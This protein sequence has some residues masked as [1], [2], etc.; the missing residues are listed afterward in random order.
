[1]RKRSAKGVAALL[2]VLCA[3]A[4]TVLAVEVPPGGEYAIPRFVPYQDPPPT[5][6]WGPFAVPELRGRQWGLYGLC[7]HGYTDKLCAAYFWEDSVRRYRSIDSTNPTYP[8]TILAYRSAGPERDSFQDLYYC[9]YDNSI[10]VHSSKRQKVFKIDAMDGHILRQFPTPATRYPTGIAFDERAKKLYLVDRMLEGGYPCSL[11]VADTLGNVESRRPLNLGYSYAGARC[12]DMDYT[13]SNPNWPS[14]LLIY[15]FFQSSGTLDS[16][17]LFELDRSSLAVLNRARLPDLAGLVNNVRGVAWDPRSGDYWIGIMQNPD[18]NIYKLDGWHTPYSAD[19]GVMALT[20]PR[21]SA[22]SGASI[23]PQMLVRNFGTAAA[24]FPVRMKIGAAYE[25]VRSKTLAAGREDTANFPVWQAR[26]RGYQKVVCITE[27]PGDMFPRN[28]TVTES[29]TVVRRDVACTQIL[30]PSGLL[31]S[32]QVVTPQA[33]VKNFGDENANFAAQFRIGGVYSETAHVSELTPNEERTISFPNWSATGRG[34]LATKC[35]TLLAS[36]MYHDNDW[37]VGTVT[38][39]V[40]DVGVVAILAPTSDTVDSGQIVT[41]RASVRNDGNYSEGF[42]VRMTIGTR[43]SDD[44]SVY[45]TPGANVNVSFASWTAFERGLLAVRCTTR[46]PGDMQNGND[47]LTGWVFVRVRDVAATAIDAPSGIV[48]SGASI[49]PQARIKNLGNTTVSL[50]VRFLVTNGYVDVQN[51]SDLTPDEERT[52]GFTPWTASPRG[53]FATRCTVGLAADQVPANNQQIG[54]VSVSVA[55]VGV[56]AIIDPSGAIDTGTVVTPQAKVKN[57]GSAPAFFPVWFRINPPESLLL[58]ANRQVISTSRDVI[59]SEAKNLSSVVQSSPSPP[60]PFDPLYEDSVWV[61]LSAGDSIIA[62]FAQWTANT[63]GTLPLEAFSALASDLNRSND[64][65]YGA[66]TV[67]PPNAIEEPAAATL[68]PREFALM[69]A[70]PNPFA[71]RTALNY[72]LPIDCPVQLLIYN[73]SGL[74]VR[75]LTSGRDR[76]GIHQVFWNGRDRQGRAVAPGLYF[77]RLEAD[78]RRF[79]RKFVKLD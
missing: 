76:A 40:S 21:T 9:R 57:Y 79:T 78:G 64:T 10:W 28:D 30:G 51:V 47:R 29:L 5:V 26:G 38:V 32:G 49:P 23:V 44:E 15:T 71:A 63:V 22:E 56:S 33:K 54:A 14:L 62:S 50:P 16:A 74:L 12:L 60:R 6:L 77:C 24:T 55:D 70:T 58:A 37:Q 59:L 13:S 31:D 67:L 36:D 73:S 3:T 61:T 11:Y 1:M 72:A 69:A 46:L 2:L 7:Y 41:P 45:V 43:Y 8:D 34:L 25:Q 35:S 42:W 48:D 19:V 4:A 18:N 53:A 39:R 68:L 27:L 20:A 65:A 52:I 75:T 66:V 17:V